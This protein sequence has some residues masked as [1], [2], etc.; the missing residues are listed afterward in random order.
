MFILT[1]GIVFDFDGVIINSSEIQ[2]QALMESYK[3]ATGDDSMPSFEEFLSHSGDSLA[4][5]FKKMNLPLS[6]VEPYRKISRSLVNLVKVYDGMKELIEKLREQGFKCALCTGK[7]RERTVELLEK[8]N[9]LELFDS[10][11]CS[12]DV[13]NPKPYPDS[14][15]LAMEN[16]GTSCENTVMVGD[17]KNDIAC[18]RAAGVAGIA[19]TWGDVPREALE[20]ESPDYIADSVDE[21]YDAINKCLGGKKF[22]RRYLV[23]DFVIAEENCNMNCAYCLTDVSRFKEKHK[24]TAKKTRKILNYIKDDKLRENVDGVSGIITDCFDV[25]I[26]KVSGGEVLMIKGIM[27]YIKAQAPKYK[28]VQ[29]LTNGLLLD[30]KMLNELKNIGNVCIQVSIDHHTL[31]GNG[32][33]TGNRRVLERILKCMDD[34]VKHEIPLEINCVLTDKNTPVIAGFADY[35]L[36]YSNRNVMMFPY[37]VRGAGRDL[38]FPKP[39]QVTGI[40]KL[41][42]NYNTYKDILAPS[43]Y[44]EYLLRFLE[45]GHREIRCIVPGMTIGTFDDGTVTPCPNYWFTSIGSLTEDERHETVQRIGRDRIYRLLL[46]AGKR[47]KECRKCFTPWETLNLYA[48]GL[49]PAKELCR[50][51]LYGF[52]GIR[53]DIIAIKNRVLS[54]A[55]SYEN[56]MNSLRKAGT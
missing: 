44:L 19:V 10:V 26:L 8:L 48:A 40:E 4:N 30:E 11:V 1:R 6:L 36:K 46:C 51:P 7:D 22:L 13:R 17:A 31:E 27:E 39:D 54:E 53:E 42:Q 23:N 9:M 56:H 20:K 24:N 47:I 3:T 25:S 12:D 43:I 18:A 34:I 55:E 33:R 41:I 14:L 21:L 5:I 16:I 32:Y 35:L 49:L 15:L 2:R 29:I 52:P 50:S 37:P 28:A 38:F 45:K